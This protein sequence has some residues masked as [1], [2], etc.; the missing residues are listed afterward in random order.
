MALSHQAGGVFLQWQQERT[1]REAVG[2]RGPRLRPWR[3]SCSCS[4]C[5]AGMCGQV[6]KGEGPCP[7]EELPETP[8]DRKAGNGAK[9]MGWVQWAGV[10]VSLD[11]PW[12]TIF[13]ARQ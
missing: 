6:E 10:T 5:D 7:S 8:A 4:A 11:R 13:E 3:E 1:R 2:E 12:V 9:V